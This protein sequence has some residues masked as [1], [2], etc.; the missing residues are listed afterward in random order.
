[1]T[2]LAP[3]DIE[4]RS[5]RDQASAALAAAITR[6]AAV[7]GL[8]HTARVLGT[9]A[10]NLQSELAADVVAAEKARQAGGLH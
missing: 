5:E 9:L 10:V 4:R 1:M 3:E 7:I 8:E 2:D 6:L